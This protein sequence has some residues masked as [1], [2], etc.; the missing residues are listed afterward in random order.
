MALNDRSAVAVETYIT[1]SITTA[2]Y[3]LGYR[4]GLI[5]CIV[6]SKVLGLSVTFTFS[7]LTF[8]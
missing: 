2:V 3:M 7:Y 6:S 8:R 1:S 5:S 4:I